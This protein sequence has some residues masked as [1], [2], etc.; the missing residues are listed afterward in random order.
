MT[1]LCRLLV[2]GLSSLAGCTAE[3]AELRPPVM[4]YG[5]D[6]CDICSM[7][8]S[9]DR[10]SSAITVRRGSRVSHLLFDDV[11]EM[12]AAPR[13]AADEMRWWSHDAGTRQWIDAETA[14]FLFSEKLMTPMGTGVAAYATK[15][16]A[17]QARTVWPGEIVEFTEARR[18][19][20]AAG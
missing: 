15:E 6:A 11:G 4:H 7:I 17:E 19:L 5:E 12:L 9:E 10:F 1:V 2:L 18:R 13:P 8:I 20:A 3:D 16:A 14:V